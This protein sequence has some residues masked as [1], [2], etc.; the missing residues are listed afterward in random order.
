M[1]TRTLT[2]SFRI[3]GAL[4]DMTSVVLADAT[5]TYGVRRE[6]T[7]ETVVVAGTAMTRAS[8][9]TYA[10]TFTEPT[11]GLSYDYVLRFVYGGQTY[12]RAFTSAATTPAPP[13][14]LYT[15]FASF[16]TGRWGV[17]NV[18]QWSD[19]DNLIAPINGIPQPDLVAIQYGFALADG[20]INAFFQ[21]GPF[22]VPLVFLDAYSLALAQNWANDLAGYF[23]Y[24]RG[25]RDSGGSKDEVGN[26]L[27]YARR[28]AL[29]EMAMYKGGV[30]R[31]NCARRWPSPTSPTSPMAVG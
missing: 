2:D 28:E 17:I 29:N 1:S 13:T 27:K 3:S 20:Q 31:L 10:Y 18:A 9:G 7:G 26:S 4:T 21:D 14:S 5:N 23:I 22:V 8:L 16:T 24:A 6:D 25:M 19:K 15:T 12:Y 11:S 30:L